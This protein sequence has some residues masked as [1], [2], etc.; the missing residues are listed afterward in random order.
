M[1]VFAYTPRVPIQAALRLLAIG[2]IVSLFFSEDDLQHGNRRRL[3]QESS[4]YSRQL[5]DHSSDNDLETI[6]LQPDFDLPNSIATADDPADASAQSD[7]DNSNEDDPDRSDIDDISTYWWKDIDYEINWQCGRFKCYFPSKSDH[8]KGYLVFRRYTPWGRKAWQTYEYAHKLES[9][10]NITQFFSSPPFDMHIPEYFAEQ[11][12]VARNGQFADRS[13]GAP[14][15]VVQPSR[16]APEQSIIYK[17]NSHRKYHT[18]NY[19]IKYA[20]QGYEGRLLK[21]IAE[22][23]PL[24]ESNPG[25]VYHVQFMIDLW[26]VGFIIL[27]WIG[28]FNLQPPGWG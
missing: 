22:T 26:M 7:F 27:I 13:D 15:V 21:G 8:T 16:N 1:T 24:V 20:H 18:L 11:V 19:L 17:Y 9:E 5:L 28:H 4:E 6:Q 10:Y 3:R 25:L 23:I 2:C 12:K 14:R